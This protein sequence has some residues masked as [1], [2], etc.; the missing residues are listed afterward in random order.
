MTNQ[1]TPKLIVRIY[2]SN[3][4]PVYNIKLNNDVIITFRFLVTVTFTNI[5]RVFILF[6]NKY[7]K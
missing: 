7:I 2:R 3:N 1:L 4:V 5:K 6:Y